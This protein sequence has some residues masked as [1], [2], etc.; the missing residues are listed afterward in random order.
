M[1]TKRS[2][3]NGVKAMIDS[4]NKMNTTISHVKNMATEWFEEHCGDEDGNIKMAK[5]LAL[6]EMT[7]ELKK[8]TPA[9]AA[10]PAGPPGL[11][12]DVNMG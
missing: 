12:P 8:N 4:T 11:T 9:A 5:I 10:A 7:Q 6:I 1:L 2:V 3:L